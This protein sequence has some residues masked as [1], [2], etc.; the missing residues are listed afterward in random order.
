MSTSLITQCPHCRT[1]FRVNQAQLSAAR[2]AVR[3]GACLQVFSALQH[4]VGG[5]PPAVPAASAA[6]ASRPAAAPSAS[7]AA[8]TA[9][10]ARPATPPAAA[11]AP[12][13][14]ASAPP[15]DDT[16]WIHDDLDLDGLDLDEELAR[17]EQEEMQLSS[18]FLSLE[19][20]PKPA[21]RML[22]GSEEP[23]DPLDEGWAEALLN[24]AGEH[25]AS[26]VDEDEPV[27]SFSAVDEEPAF[28]AA[29]DDEPTAAALDEEDDPDGRREP[30]LGDPTLA[31]LSNEP[32]RLTWERPR[33]PWG[34]W[35]GWTALNLIAAGALFA[36]YA[37]YNFAEL[38]RQDSWRPW[39][40]QLCP[41]LGCRVPSKVDVSQIRSSNLLVRAHPSHPKALVV[42][43]ILYNR[44]PFAQPFPLLEMRFTDLNGQVL[45][46][47]RFRPSQYLAG[48]LAGQ[49]EMPPQTPIR[50]ALEILDP[51]P[52]AVNYSLNFLSPE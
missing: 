31:Q 46:S 39:F 20:A 35:L 33:R 40:E 44:A 21:D 12:S 25:P 7:P 13:Q 11:Q 38:A 17:L 2:G 14:P 29:D 49:A 23:R 6:P 28:G 8:R 4:L 41:S 43:A 24:E 50:I 5:Q 18:E 32:L 27:E 51:G 16:L 48:E 45:A 47:G 37:S 10:P 26:P 34:R 30:S 36:Q 15:K 42:D 22:T 1:S 9:E 3:C 52:Q 19:S